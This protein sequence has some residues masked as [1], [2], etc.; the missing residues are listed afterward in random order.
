M[1]D[2]FVPRD[3]VMDN[4]VRFGPALLGFRQL[5]V[6]ENPPPVGEEHALE[7]QILHDCQHQRWSRHDLF[8]G[9]GHLMDLFP[10]PRVVE[11]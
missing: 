11:A 10:K 1:S 9:D 3:D 6:E 2:P 8:P 4:F 5:L 7:P